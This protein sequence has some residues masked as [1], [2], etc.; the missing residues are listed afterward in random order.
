[1][2]ACAACT[3]N[4]AL[5]EDL[6]VSKLVDLA[7]VGELESLRPLVVDARVRDE[8]DERDVLPDRGDIADLLSNLV[9]VGELL[10]WRAREAPRCRCTLSHINTIPHL[11]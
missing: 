6:E 8:D 5:D 11:L 10:A 1:M 2:A 4:D 7:L 9:Q 3:R